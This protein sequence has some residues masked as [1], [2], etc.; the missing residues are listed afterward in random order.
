M[1]NGVLIQIV[2][3][4]VAAAEV[5]VIVALGFTTTSAVIGNPVHPFAVGVI[6]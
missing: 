4:F 6:V 3:A 5:K 2:C 1:V